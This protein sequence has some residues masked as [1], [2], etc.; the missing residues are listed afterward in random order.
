[1]K[2]PDDIEEAIAR[3]VAYQGARSGALTRTGY[4][5]TRT[6][7]YEA[8]HALRAVIHR[9]VEQARAA[10][11]ADGVQAMREAAARIVEQHADHKPPAAV[12]AMVRALATGHTDAAGMPAGQSA[13]TF[14]QDHT[15]EGSS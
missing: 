8:E 10:Q 9:A 12:A 3:L 15:A 2:L 13:R 6:L 5:V 11:P 4:N 1:M 7:A 14:P